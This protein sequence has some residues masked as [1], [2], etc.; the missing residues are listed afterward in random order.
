MTPLEIAFGHLFGYDAS[1]VHRDRRFDTPRAALEEVVRDSLLRPPCGVAFSGGKDSSLILAVAMHVA[2]RDGLPEPIAITKVFPD[3]SAAEESEWQSLVVRHLSLD[4]WERIVIG[5]ELDVVGP[6][7]RDRLVEHGV[8]WPV[9]GHGD[10][11]VLRLLK[12]G[13]LIDG[14]GGDEVLGVAAH[15]VAPV[16]RLVRSR[17]RPRLRHIRSAVG[18][19][20]PGR[21]R[22][23]YRRRVWKDDQLTPWLRPEPHR[24]FLAALAKF[25]AEEPLSFASSVRL[26]PHRR[27]H[28]VTLRN[29]RFFAR[30]F[31]VEFASPLLDADVVDALA[32]DGGW[33]GRG[34]RAMT[35]RAIASDLLP[36]AIVARRSKASFNA[37]FWSEH[38]QRFADQWTGDGV[39]TEL[40]DVDKL[41]ELWLS[42]GRKLLSMA[43]LQ[44][45]WLAT[46]PPKEVA[47]T[48]A[49][50]HTWA[51]TVGGG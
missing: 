39:D 42:E 12:G 17:R 5:D 7:A 43:L 3:V 2:R 41:R 31:D 44:Q 26:V 1:P 11:P 14:E 9:T 47:P 36:D 37:A 40:V 25:E 30:S 22:T 15:R 50:R 13:S 29:R 32:R 49:E 33:L 10:I 23:T 35:M 38:A 45:A 18:A 8:V 20:A 28:A 16:T 19:V 6:L 24:Q 51:P 4:H 27:A 48:T 34:D 46:S 21:V